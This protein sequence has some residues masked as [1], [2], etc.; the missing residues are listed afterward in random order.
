MCSCRSP[1]RRVCAPP[2]HIKKAFDLRWYKVMRRA[3]K[4]HGI[5]VYAPP[6]LR[7]SPPSQGG[8]RC[9]EWGEG[10]RDILSAPAS[11]SGCARGGYRLKI[12]SLLG[13]SISPNPYPHLKRPLLA[14]LLDESIASPKAHQ[15]P[16]ASAEFCLYLHQQNLKAYAYSSHLFRACMPDGRHPRPKRRYRYQ[17]P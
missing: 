16:L 13:N 10:K 5:R 1:L 3:P 15:P 4:G 8:R 6:L 14:L 9:R 7:P 2:L 12:K 17:Y 11:Q